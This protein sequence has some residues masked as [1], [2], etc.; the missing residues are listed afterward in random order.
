M[1][2]TFLK[3]L[4]AIARS[5]HVVKTWNVWCQSGLIFSYTK[6]VEF[7]NSKKDKALRQHV[8]HIIKLKCLIFG[9]IPDTSQSSKTHEHNLKFC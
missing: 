6:Y 2:Y 7:I 9:I 8:I 5:E 3:L 4:R 1:M